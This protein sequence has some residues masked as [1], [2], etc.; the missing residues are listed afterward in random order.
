MKKDLKLETKDAA[1]LLGVGPGRIRQMA[2]RGQLRAERTASGTR[3]FDADEVRR[4]KAERD[5]K[6]R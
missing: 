4:V 2:D 3:L 5:K 6:K 1:K